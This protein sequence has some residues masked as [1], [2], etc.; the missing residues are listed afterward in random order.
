[1]FNSLRA[2]YQRHASFLLIFTL[3]VTFRLLALLL[4][5]PGG[6]IADFSD[7]DFYYT[8]GQL[9][10]MGYRTFA[11]LWTAY[12]PLF[13]ALM[14][15]AFELASR[16]P[17]WV[18]PR[19]FFH[20]LFGLE[21]LCFEAGNLILIY[22]LSHKLQIA[23]QPTKTP[24]HL[25]T[26]SPCHP[27]ILYALLFTPVYTLL[28]WFEMMPLFFLLLGLDLLL[29]QRRWGWVGSAAAAALGFLIKLTPMM[30][31]PIAVRWLGAR[32]SW[33]ALRK[34]W[35]RTRTPGNLGRPLVYLLL[36][37]AVVG[38]VGYLLVD[39]NPTLALSSLRVNNIRPPWQSIWAVLEHYYG[40]GLVPLDM[41]NLEGLQKNL[42]TTTLP[43]PW[44]T[45]GFGLLYLW[46]YTRPYDWQQPRTVIGFTAISVLWLFLYSKGW[47]PQFLLS[48][49]VFVVL[50]LPTPRGMMIA[51]VLSLVNVVEANLFLILLPDEH[52]IM[53]GTVL[54]R[55]AL[56]IL[57]LVEFLGQIWPTPAIG[58]R[59]EQ[60]SAGLSWGV[61]VATLLAALL[62]APRV[63]Q[64]YQARRLAQHPCRPALEYLQAQQAWPNRT[65]V[66]DQIEVWRDFYPWLRNQYTIRVIDGYNTADRP[67]PTVI[68]ERLAEYVGQQEFWWLIENSV[69]RSE[70]SL[71]QPTGDRLE[72][73]QLGQC[74]LER[75][76][77]LDAQPQGVAMVDGGP[78][79]L[80]AVAQGAAQVGTDFHLVL[81]WQAESPVTSS[82]TVFTQVLDS[83]G[84]MVAQQDNLPV[85]GLAP[86]TSWAAGTMIRDPY[87]LALPANL[88]AGRYQ[89]LVGLYTEAGRRTWHLPD[90]TT[91]DHVTFQLDV[92]EH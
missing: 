26:L 51:I 9:G 1:M 59:L 82:Y 48:V 68:N 40:Y 89:L 15:P 83:T 20:L 23:P 38:G 91:A 16:I 81:Y 84:Q 21:L 71:P 78:I 35:F 18:E 7:Y 42:W 90:G 49:L 32:F 73:Q 30:L 4:F 47:S 53:T 11:N 61:M 27:V 2:F 76:I 10:A 5:R 54:V 56:L 79:R 33:D 24:G 62:G 36:F 65:I 64:A 60:A 37:F 75:W 50:L 45:V 52:W 39:G 85:N 69:P 66:S 70:K 63:A 57:L 17:P 55:T 43:W 19:F 92:R 44:I 74:T 87:Q 58:R 86:T 28:G 80:R 12:P 31:V 14:L 46:L 88:P 8:W 67:W 13:P 29:S 72:S 41:R 6:F 3:F 25:V 34:E 77:Q 22:R